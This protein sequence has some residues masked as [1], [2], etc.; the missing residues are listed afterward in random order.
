MGLVSFALFLLIYVCDPLWL[1]SVRRSDPFSMCLDHFYSTISAS[2]LPASPDWLPITRVYFPA[3]YYVS[4]SLLFIYILGFYII[5]I[6]SFL[7]SISGLFYL[8]LC[9]TT[10]IFLKSLKFVFLYDW[11]VFHWVCVLCFLYPLIPID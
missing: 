2:L 3:S 4:F 7:S 5:E 11:I 1:H 9:Q 10:F 8:V 6:M